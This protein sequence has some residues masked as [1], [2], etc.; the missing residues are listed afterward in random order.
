ML[1]DPEADQQRALASLIE[2]IREEL[3]VGT[4]REELAARLSG[5]GWDQDFSLDHLNLAITQGDSSSVSRLIGTDMDALIARE[6]SLATQYTDI[7]KQMG[8][9]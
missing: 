3:S 1:G 4:P 7:Q 2:W 6:Y 5:L 9:K 8:A